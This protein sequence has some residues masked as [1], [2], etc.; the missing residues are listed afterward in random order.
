MVD[1]FSPEVMR[2]GWLILGAVLI[3]AEFVVPGAVIMFFGGGAILTGIAVALGWLPGP[4]SQLMF[5]MISSILLVGALRRQLRR[6][7]PALESYHPPDEAAEM[8]GRIVLVLEDISSDDDSGRVRY[9]GTSWQ[10]RTR[11]GR[12]SAGQSAKISGRDDMI[13]YVEATDETGSG[14]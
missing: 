1:F 8:R 7:F 10:A 11:V 9:Q 6:W 3:V 14:G 13:I 12:I 4:G 5:W 2:T